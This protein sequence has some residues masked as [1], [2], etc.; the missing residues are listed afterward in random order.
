MLATKL[1]AQVIS[2]NELAADEQLNPGASSARRVLAE[3]KDS[4]RLVVVDEAHALRNEDTSWYRAME[5]LLGGTEKQVVLLTATPINNGL[6][7]LYN[8]VMLF[9]RHDR[10]LARAGI[11][12]IRK[13]FL[14]AGANE[15][16]P[17]DLSP[18][19]AFPVGRRGQRAPRP[20]VHRALLRGRDVPRRH[21]VAFPK[22]KLRTRRYDLDAAHP[23][24]FE[25][26]TVEIDALTMAR[27]RPS[28]FEQCG[29]ETSVEAQ[30]GGLVKS[31]LLKRFESCW[32]ACLETVERM[33]AAHDAFLAAWGEGHVLSREQ[34]REAAAAEEDESGLAGWLEQKLDD[35][36]GTR[37]R[38]EF[39]DEYG[40]A[41]A[42]DRDRLVRIRER[43]PSST[44]SRTR[45]W[46]CCARCSRTRRPRRSRCSRPT[47][48][49]SATS[50][51][52]CPTASAGVS[53]SP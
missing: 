29:E 52:T 35:G 12:S 36:V 24:L 47:Q 7:D 19:V 1:S 10:G 34:L 6:W 51:S 17:E 23:G 50:T 42:E 45:S 28:A 49:P 3:D 25:R 32:A 39:V 5:R 2:F 26:I 41:V 38:E 48:R 44:R 8:L 27:Y 15:R 30:L 14:L 9:S 4:Y 22:P 46:R 20:Q 13:L 37:P 11:D 18:E 40:A 16:D 33:L 53:G 43:S 31:G 21:P